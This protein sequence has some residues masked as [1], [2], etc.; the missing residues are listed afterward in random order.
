MHF[1]QYV[2][3]ISCSICICIS[4]FFYS[5]I[6]HPVKFV[7]AVGV[8]WKCPLEIQE[9]IVHLNLANW[10]LPLKGNYHWRSELLNIVPG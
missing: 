8:S 6:N 9:R 7:L 3:L 2:Y 10:G 4:I 5:K 1:S